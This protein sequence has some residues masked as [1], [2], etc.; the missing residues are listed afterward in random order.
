LSAAIECREL[1]CRK[2]KPDKKGAGSFSPPA[3]NPSHRDQ[4]LLFSTAI[5]VVTMVVMTV[6]CFG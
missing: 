1:A 5:V 3:P 6:A 4:V 2:K